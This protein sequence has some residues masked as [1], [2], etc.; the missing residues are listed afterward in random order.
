MKS[1]RFPL[2]NGGGGFRWVTT[3]PNRKDALSFMNGVGLGG[4][5]DT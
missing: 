1:G 2:S 4:G 3:D 5:L